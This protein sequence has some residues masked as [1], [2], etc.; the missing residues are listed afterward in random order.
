MR[1]V[2]DLDLC[3]GHATCEGEAP[4]IFEVPKHGKVN[5]LADTVSEELRPKVLSAVEYC[6]THALS[7]MED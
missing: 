4:E 3:Q 7:I 6:P 1:V 5:V 2:V